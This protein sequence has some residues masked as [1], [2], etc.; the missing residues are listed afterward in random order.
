M[1]QLENI[2]RILLCGSLCLI[3]AAFCSVFA[4]QSDSMD[5]IEIGLITCSPHEEVYSLYGHTA[6][7]YHNLKTKEDLTFNYGVFNYNQPFFVLRF[8][9]G[10]T[11]YELGIAPFDDFCD[12]YKKW[13]SE[14]S[15][16]VLNLTPQEK[17]RLAQALA[18][19][20]E[21][22]NRVYRYNFFYDNCATRPRDIIERSLDG[23]LT[24]PPTVIPAPTF[25]QMVHEHTA[26]H[27]WAAMGN[28]LLLGV[29]ADMP[30]TQREQHFLPE[31]LKRDFDQAYILT[32]DSARP[33]VKERRIVVPHGKQ[34]VESEFPLSPNECMLVLT[35]IAL[36]LFALEW[37]RR[38]TYAWWDATLM[39]VTGSA[40][41][42][43]GVMFFSEHPATSSNLQA[44]LLNP[45]HL[46]FLRQVVRRNAKTRYWSLLIV[47]IVLF[48]VG[49]FWQDYAEGMYYL[50]LILL[51]RYCI[52]KAEQRSFSV[53]GLLKRKI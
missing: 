48:V 29:R 22:E 44:L 13:G 14:V 40:G 51:S 30:T 46:I 25:R 16:Q 20:W 26:H 23:L 31:N 19:N 3:Q 7:R 50:A 8:V 34:V 39:A 35:A 42:L 6:L 2:F 45:L 15:E 24:Y 10:K 27:P 17:R 12:Y 21:P 1:K 52:H 18:I 4:Q 11:D 43:I 36:G 37:R 53:K 49:G 41:I 38:R 5:S 9:F 32:A 28:D 33:L 47:L